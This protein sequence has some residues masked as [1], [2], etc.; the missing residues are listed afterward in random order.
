MALRDMLF[1]ELKTELEKK[2]LEEAKDC[3]VKVR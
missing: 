2:L 1:P 3:V